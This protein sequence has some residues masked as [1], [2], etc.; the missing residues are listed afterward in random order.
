MANGNYRLTHSVTTTPATSGSDFY[1]E[2]GRDFDI[3]SYAKNHKLNADEFGADAVAGI[4]A[5]VTKLKQGEWLLV[6]HES[7]GKK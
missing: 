5:A 7:V 6:S 1:V 3:G 4:A 2:A